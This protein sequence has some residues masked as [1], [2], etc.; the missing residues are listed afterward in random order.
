M[1][2]LRFKKIDA[3]TTGISS[4]NPAGYI[5]LDND[6]VLNQEEMQR[7]ALELK[8]FVNEVGYVSKAGDDYKLKYYSSECEVPFCGHATIAIMYDLLSNDKDLLDAKEVRIN[9]QAGTLSVFNHI[10]EEDAAFIMAPAAKFLTQN[11]KR[12][13]VAGILGIDTKK[14]N[15]AMPVRLI[16]GG[17]RTLIVPLCSLEESLKINPHQENLRVFCL[18]KDIDI[19]LIFTEE[20]HTASCDYRTRVFAPKFGYLEDLATGSGNSAFGYYLI[21]EN[22]WNGDFTIEQGPDR[23]NPNFVKIKRLSEGGRENILFG[24]CA[25]TRIEGDYILY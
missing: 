22:M 12:E 21:D 5:Y 4:G 2:K 3:F 24:G 1:K 7:I 25:K 6:E 23:A 9:V 18:E 14:I 15:D 17:L 10:K 16:D 11:L 8:G 19:V 13:E 20:T